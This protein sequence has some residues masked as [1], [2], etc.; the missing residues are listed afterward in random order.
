[1]RL[2]KYPGNPVLSPNP[3]NKWESLVTTNPGAWYEEDEGTVYLLYRAA[4]TDP[5]HRIY[6]GLAVSQDGYRFERVS[7]EPVFGPGAEGFDAGCVEDPRIVKMGEYYFIT[8]AARPFPPGQYWLPAERRGYHPPKC[9]PQF[10]KCLRE[11][12]TVSGLAITKDFRTFIRAGRLT[13][14]LLDDRDVILFPEKVGGKYILIHRPLEW[15]GEEYGTDR[16]SIWI[17]AS[18]DLLGF[19]FKQSKLLAKPEF[20]WEA[21]RIGGSTPPIKTDH[22]WLFLYHGAG[23]DRFYRIGAMLLDLEEPWKILHRSPDWL[24]EPDQYYEIEGRYR[25]VVFPCGNVVIEGTLFVYYGGADQY[26]GVA[27][28]PLD[29]LLD[30]LRSC[31]P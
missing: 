9:P 28:C 22:G 27:T 1:M 24:M 5:E 2:Q 21:T 20:E 8:Y 17:C 31:P 26:V 14:P 18:E 30:H 6:L 15:V 29:E 11:N 7:D 12:S 3:K 4:G 19:D 25:G 16:P 10:P 23:S 13:H